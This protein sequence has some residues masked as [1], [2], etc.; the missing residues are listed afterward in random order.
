MRRF[1]V[2]FHDPDPALWLNADPDP[3]LKM[4]AVKKFQSQKIML[5]F[6]KKKIKSQ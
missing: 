2:N 4:N 6:N 5:N 1:F 3:A